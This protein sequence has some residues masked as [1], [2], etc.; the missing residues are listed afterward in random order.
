M[1]GVFVENYRNP[2]LRNLAVS[3]EEHLSLMNV[4]VPLYVIL[5]S[6]IL[7][8]KPWHSVIIDPRAS[9]AWLEVVKRYW[10]SNEYRTLNEVTAG[11]P[12]LARH[13]AIK[14]IEALV[15]QSKREEKRMEESGRS[16]NSEVV[17]R[18]A[19]AK[20]EHGDVA[21]LLVAAGVYGVEARDVV[22]ST[23]KALRDAARA[24][25]EEL[26]AALLFSHYGVPV[27]RML[28]KP[29]TLRQLMASKMVVEFVR[30]L[31]LL[32]RVSA[33]AGATRY[34][35]MVFGTPIGVKKMQRWSELARLVPVDLV[36]D[37]IFA[38]RV[39]S[40]SVRVRESYGGIPSHVIYLDK[41]GSMS[42]RIVYI[43]EPGRKEYVS[44]I[45][46]AAA[47]AIA[48]V[49]RLRSVGASATLKLFD[50]DV[51]DPVRDV[52]EMINVLLRV[53]ADSGT[54]ITNVLNDAVENHKDSRVL[55]VTDGIDVVS[56][57]AVK[58]ARRVGLDVT[59]IFIDTDN[60]LLRRN[61]RCVHLREAK[62]DIL[63]TV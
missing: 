55:V 42:Y 2:T 30:F 39:A 56:E 27:A 8:V 35:S 34:P 25:K 50:T 6:I 52:V 1:K 10:S 58:R 33:D 7:H 36:D 31:S 44:K 26:E 11:D 63:L 38:Y 57:D 53:E 54:N 61:F 40:R 51:H 48:L 16:G 19:K 13:A 21:A 3:V 47:S 5:D 17:G 45:S 24:A 14:F 22:N 62:P 32:R 37:D 49:T 60:E 59:F 12:L 20:E 46:F 4:K 15:K 29:D 18:V 28:E 9:G 41:S 43:P 23:V